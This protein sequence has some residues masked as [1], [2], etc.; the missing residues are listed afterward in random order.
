MI[1]GPAATAEATS[2]KLLL[3][4]GRDIATAQGEHADGLAELKE[5][6]PGKLE[7][8]SNWVGPL[9]DDARDRAFAFVRTRQL[10]ALL[11]LAKQLLEAVSER[12]V[13]WRSELDQIY[14]HLVEGE[15]A[16]EHREA[17]MGALDETQLKGIERLQV[18]LQRLARVRK[19]PVSAAQTSKMHDTTMQ[20]YQDVLRKLAVQ[21][22]DDRAT[23]GMSTANAAR[24]SASV[25]PDGRP[26]FTLG[27]LGKE[28]ANNDLSRLHTSLYE[29]FVSRIHHRLTPVDIFDY[30]AYL[31]AQKLS[32][33]EFK[34]VAN[35]FLAGG[36]SDVL[37]NTGAEDTDR[38]MFVY[39]LPGSKQKELIVDKLTESVGAGRRGGGLS[40]DQYSSDLHAVAHQD[41]QS[42]RDDFA[43]QDVNR[44]YPEYAKL[45]TKA[46]SGNKGLDDLLRRAQ[47]YHIVPPELEAWYI[48]RFIERWQVRDAH[49]KGISLPPRVVRLLED[50]AMIQAFVRC[51]MTGAVYRTPEEL[52]R[53]L[54]PFQWRQGSLPDGEGESAALRRSSP[55]RR[56]ILPPAQGLPRRCLQHHH[57]RSGHRELPQGRS[58][59]L[60]DRDIARRKARLQEARGRWVLG[61]LLPG[62]RIREQCH[63]PAGC[64][65]SRRHSRADEILWGFPH[66]RGSAQPY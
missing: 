53:W 2:G 64:R 9:Q 32:D 39:K 3:E 52:W 1:D 51:L 41:H 45:R 56:D 63:E 17:I 24:W 60:P 48:E 59:R 5:Y 18:R 31:K 58:G 4:A 66:D 50:P 28:H 36:A 8:L 27:L 22:D 55:G 29:E 33:D 35:L 37:L 11:T 13:L 30:L 21:S 38:A 10:H 7:S 19:C 40:A 42:H 34:S 16:T 12:L 54:Q 65:P 61:Y 46:V 20:G 26:Q 6:R 23:I 44:C 14:D 57:G 15:P 43:V 47:V 25:S 62:E 49:G